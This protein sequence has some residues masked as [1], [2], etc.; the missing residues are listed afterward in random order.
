MPVS[1]KSISPGSRFPVLFSAEP[2][3][4]GFM[5]THIAL[6]TFRD[7]NCLMQTHTFKEVKN[8]KMHL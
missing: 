6:I 7:S 8:N 2:T 3:F 5:Q 4:S 1:R